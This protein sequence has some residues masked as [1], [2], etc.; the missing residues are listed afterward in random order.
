VKR[1][2]KWRGGKQAITLAVVKVVCECGDVFRLEGSYPD[3][4]PTDMAHC[5][6][7]DRE[8]RLVVQVETKEGGNPHG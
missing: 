4:P 6:G 2:L 5:L 7:C 8:F 3:Y 1:W